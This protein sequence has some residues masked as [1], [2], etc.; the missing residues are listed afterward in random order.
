MGSSTSIEPRMVY[1]LDEVFI[2]K[3][4][5]V[6][7]LLPVASQSAAPLSEGWTVCCQKFTISGV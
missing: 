7:T 5:F 2:E 1:R 3:K 6:F 4:A